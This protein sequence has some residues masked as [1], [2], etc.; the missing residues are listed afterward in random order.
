MASA[1]DVFSIVKD[2]F[3]IVTPSVVAYISYRSNKKT[4]EDVRLE[5]EKSLKEKDAETVQIRK[6]IPETMSFQV[7]GVKTL[8]NGREPLMKHP[9]PVLSSLTTDFRM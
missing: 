5:I 6:K 1:N 3:L 4:K 9:R 8:K 2:I 7:S